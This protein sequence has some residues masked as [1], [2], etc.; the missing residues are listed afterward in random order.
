MA[1]SIVVENGSGLANANSY[2]S[3]SDADT[4][5][6]NRANS[7]WAAYTTDQK[8]A[9]LIMATQYL[10]ANYK[11]R[12]GLA[13]STQA[14]GWPRDLE[15]DNE[16]RTIT[17]VPQKVKHA[18]AEMAIVAAANGSLLPTA[19]GG[20]GSVK[21]EKVGPLEVEYT[22]EGVSSDDAYTYVQLLLAGLGRK[23]GGTILKL[24]RV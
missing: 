22:S 20:S 1:V 19:S 7:T 10:D 9:A 24:G 14:L 21:R 23:R 2:L 13:T 11:W 15:F 16:G 4:Y 8:A 12:G 5:W 17:G 3:V 18:T 6:A